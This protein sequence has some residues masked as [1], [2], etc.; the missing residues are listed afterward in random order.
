MIMRKLFI[1]II[2]FWLYQGTIA[3]NTEEIGVFQADTTWSKEI[4]KFPIGFAKEIPYTGY[5]NLRFHPEWPKKAANGFWTYI[6]AWQVAGIQ[7]LTEESLTL[8]MQSYYDGLVGGGMS[9]IPKSE[10]SFKKDTNLNAKSDF[11]GTIKL[12]DRFHTQKVISLNVLVKSFYCNE[13]NTSTIIFKISPKPLN[14]A[15]WNDFNKVTLKTSICP[16]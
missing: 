11:S 3:Q 14:H 8:Y 5:E 16:K 15:V 7:K 6:F 1:A 10:I 9:N 2:S 4:I 12:F 13:Q